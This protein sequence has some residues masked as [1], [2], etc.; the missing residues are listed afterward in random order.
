MATGSDRDAGATAGSA[1]RLIEL[2]SLDRVHHRVVGQAL[3]HVTALRR[4]PVEKLG[5]AIREELPD[6]VRDSNVVSVE[7]AFDVLLLSE[8]FADAVLLYV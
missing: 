3:G 1:V 6:G 5:N 2:V 4:V 7:P 8:L